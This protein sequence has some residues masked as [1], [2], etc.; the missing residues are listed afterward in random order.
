MA[1]LT[2][3]DQGGED[4]NNCYDE[5]EGASQVTAGLI[6]A[7]PM[8]GFSNKNGWYNYCGKPN[9]VT[10][11]LKMV[12]TTHFWQ[13]FGWFII[14]FTNI[15]GVVTG[16]SHRNFLLEHF[17]ESSQKTIHHWQLVG[18][19]RHAADT[20]PLEGVLVLRCAIHYPLE[21]LQIWKMQVAKMRVQELNLG[22][23]CLKVPARCVT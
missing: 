5:W 12:Y 17:Q 23:G 2:K 7:L 14:G 13:S 22:V 8:F 3:I 20:P 16:Q 19:F 11:H 9:A 1:V 6:G 21:G 4:Q 10:F 18:S 15:L